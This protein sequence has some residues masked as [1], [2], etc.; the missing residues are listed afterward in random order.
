MLS[1]L[2]KSFIRNQKKNKIITVINVVGLVL[3]MLSTL[4]IL[5]Y[6][7]Y[8]RSYDS[9][10]K[11][12]D[13]LYRVVYDR[14]GQE[15]LMWKTTNFYVP[16]GPY[17]KETFPEVEEYATLFRKYNITINQTDKAGNP[18]NYV[19]DKCYY[20]TSSMFDV[21][22]VPLIS[23][24]RQCLD[25]PNTVVISERAKMKYFGDVDPIGQIMT[26][27]HKEKYQVTGVFQT[28]PANSH[29]QSDLFFSMETLYQRR[30]AML[31]DWVGDGALLYLILKDG[32]N[33]KDFEAKAFPR[34]IQENY[35]DYLERSNQRDDIYLQPIEDIHLKSFIEYELEPP[36]NGKAIAILFGFSIFFLLVAWINYANLSSARAVERA[37]EIGIKK[38]N[39]SSRS[40]LMRQFI[41]EALI[42]NLICYLFTLGLFLF[43]D[44]YFRML[45]GINGDVVVF[46]RRFWMLFSLSVFAGA[47]LSSLYPAL[48]LVAYRP[49]SVLKGRFATSNHGFIFRKGLVTVQFIVSILLLCGTIIGY[50]QVTFLM[51]KDLGVDCHS[52]MVIT[53]P[54]AY[55][56]REQFNQR[57]EAFRDKLLQIPGIDQ[58]TYCSDIPGDEVQGFWGGYKKGGKEDELLWYFGV[59]ADDH[60][61]DLFKPKLLA[62]R[63]F[64]EDDKPEMNYIILNETGLRRLGYQDPEAA[65]NQRA[66]NHAKQECTIIGV[67][68]DF[69]FR[70]IKTDAVATCY[71]NNNWRKKFLILDTSNLGNVSM[72]QFANRAQA[73]FREFFPGDPFNY[74]FL[75]DHLAADL[76]TDRTFVAVFSIFS[77]LAIVIS[78]IGIIGLLLITVGQNIRDFGVRKVLGAEVVNISML[79]TRQFSWQFFVA[80]SIALP[81]AFWG[82]N[83]WIR[84]SYNYHV[85]L[86]AIYLIVP[87]LVIL[88]VFLAVMF[89]IARRTYRINTIEVLNV[90]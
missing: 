42:F 1:H 22:T 82:F 71:T 55:G 81:V 20:A 56:D 36:G 21:L 46:G 40:L 9:F 86:K 3:G 72:N 87:V 78:L 30:P 47:A 64:R 43:V 5:E 25:N 58:Y 8:E 83:K 69:H 45:T 57:V 7:L 18:I 68:K 14:Y 33:Y 70:S 84:E 13:N 26:I 52:K 4:L 11:N 80:T 61:L 50:K 73:I 12:A 79:L 48:V 39:G 89:M 74:S 85:D 27:N 90:E 10:R 76:S 88:L 59:Q 31:N 51:Q 23:G 24:S 44:P 62:G 15:G 34:M 41:A 32:T 35:A 67:F 54:R 65:I 77:I 49:V 29:I 19:E 16:A 38:I 53:T 2:L 17:L 60:F 66:I 63:F 75:E 28:I 37:K 6:V